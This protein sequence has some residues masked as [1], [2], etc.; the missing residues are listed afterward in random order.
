MRCLILMPQEFL[1]KY[2][3]IHMQGHHLVILMTEYDDLSFHSHLKLNFIS[4]DP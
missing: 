3:E 2:L 1:G 4:Y